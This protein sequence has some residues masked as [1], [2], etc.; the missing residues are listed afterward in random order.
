VRIW[1]EVPDME[2]S[3]IRKY[4]RERYAGIARQGGSCCGPKASCC[5][6]DAADTTG[7]KIGYSEEELKA[8]PQGANLGLGCGN[9]IALASLKEGETVLD[10]GSGAGFDCFLAAREVGPEGRAIGVDMTPEMV[11]KARENARKG[12]YGNVEFRLGEI[13]HLPT[14]DNSVD[15]VI[16]NCVINLS[17]AKGEVFAEAYRVLK[18]GGRIMISDLVLSRELPGPVARSLAAYAGCIS[19]AIRKDEYL[20]LMEAAGFQGVQIVQEST[21]PVGEGDADAQA[22]SIADAFDVPAGVARE[23][24]GAILSVRVFG[25]KPV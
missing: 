11:E 18:P 5:G 17:T 19:G 3:R 20:R 12:G 13:E 23:A 16:S 4:V 2:E 6:E 10:L 15:A 14:A 7:R 1:K 22:R 9:P 24:A 21:F 8:V 25:E